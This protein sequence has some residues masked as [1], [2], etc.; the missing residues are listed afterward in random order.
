LDG[1]ISSRGLDKRTP[2]GYNDTLNGISDMKTK[3]VKK[4][5]V[6]PTFLTCGV[7]L[8]NTRLEILI[9]E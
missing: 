3:S 2:F 7:V 6:S 1:K 5:S 9:L 8:E 4:K